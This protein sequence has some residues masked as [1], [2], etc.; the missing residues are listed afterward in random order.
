MPKRH[1]FSLDAIMKRLFVVVTVS[2]FALGLAGWWSHRLSSRLLEAGD[3]NAL[4]KIETM[5]RD[6]AVLLPLMLVVFTVIVFRREL[7]LIFG[8]RLAK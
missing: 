4:T 6:F 5:N 1:P 3:P 8:V 2:G 7:L